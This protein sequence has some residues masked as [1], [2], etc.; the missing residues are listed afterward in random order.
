MAAS[1]SRLLDLPLPGGAEAQA[2]QQCAAVVA[3]LAA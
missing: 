1:P 3:E 2:F